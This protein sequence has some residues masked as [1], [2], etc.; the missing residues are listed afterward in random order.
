MASR[1]VYD[2]CRREITA[3]ALQ[4]KKLGVGKSTVNIKPPT[5]GYDGMTV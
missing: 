2:P 4:N 1:F 5:I 3:V